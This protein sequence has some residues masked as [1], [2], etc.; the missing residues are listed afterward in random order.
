[1]SKSERVYLRLVAA[2][3]R[4]TNQSD[5]SIGPEEKRD[6]LRRKQNASSEVEEFR[7]QYRREKV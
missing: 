6:W 3:Y 2:M 5:G 4:S 1:M 7:R